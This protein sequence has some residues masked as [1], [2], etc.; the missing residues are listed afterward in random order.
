MTRLSLLVITLAACTTELKEFDRVD[1][2]GTAADLDILYVFD[3]SADRANYDTMAGQL[4]VLSTQ[5]ASIDGQVPNLHV[6]VVTADLG[7]KGTEDE[8]TP[9]TFRNCAGGGDGGKL[10]V[11]DA[12]LPVPYLEDLRGEN[13]TRVRNFEGDDDA[14][15][16]AELALLVNPSPGK[17]GCEVI[18]PMEAMR[19]ALDPATNPG[20]LRDKAQLMVVFMT[21]DDDCSLRTGSFLGAAQPNAARCATEGVI[22]VNNPDPGRPV[23]HTT[24][25]PRED[26]TKVIPVSEYV[27]F[28]RGNRTPLHDKVIY[29]DAAFIA[30]FFCPQ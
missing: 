12:A 10:T 2:V 25:R 20:F 18:Q 22:C 21:S 19:R 17:V 9:A 24:C 5:L 1:E 23:T 6:G 26:S 11:F 30:K 14:D 16:A 3:T 15:L 28:L 29:F 13:G 8:L 4:D 7:T 27:T